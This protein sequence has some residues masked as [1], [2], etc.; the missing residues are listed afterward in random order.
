ML[1]LLLFSFA[2]PALGQYDT[3]RLQSYNVLNYPGSTSAGRNPHF[4]TIVNNIDPD[5]LVVQEMNDG[6]GMAQFFNQV[7][8]FTT[9]GLYDTVPFHNGAFPNDSNN[10]LFFK[11]SKVSFVSANYI[12]T[13]LRDIAEYVL[14]PV[15]S[16]EPIRIYSVHLKASSGDSDKIKRF[17]ETSILRNHLNALPAGTNFIVTGDFNIYGTDE[18]AYVKLTGSEADNDGR[19]FDPLTMPGTWNQSIYAPYHTQSPRVRQ[20][21]GGS[22]GGLDDRFDLFLRSSSMQDNLLTATYTPYGNDGQHFNDSVNQMPNT[23]VD[24]ITANAIHYASDHLPMFVDLIFPTPPS[25]PIL[26]SPGDGSTDITTSPILAWHFTPTTLTYHLEVSMDSLFGTVFI[27]DSTLTDT[28]RAIGPLDIA[29]TYFWRVKAKNTGGTSA[30]STSAEFTTEGM[31]YSYSIQNGWNLISVPF[32]VGS[33]VK[34][35]LFP[36]ATSQAFLFN[37]IAGYAAQDTL[38]EG[39]GYWLKF[40]QDQTV[41]LGGLSVPTDTVSVASGWNLMGTISNPVPVSSIA[42]EP[43]GILSSLFYSYSGSYQQA[44]TL[45]PGNAYWIKSTTAGS[46]IL[47]SP[48]PANRPTTKGLKP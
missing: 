45:L 36:T 16:A 27:N 14:Q 18:T 2:T 25:Q 1:Y 28:T 17:L 37:G 34:A 15:N 10:G 33:G 29:T 24:S 6:A 26:A 47:T 23:A 39:V 7:M 46:I 19:C 9:P 38:A 20:F 30:Y 32:D 35:L 31:V 22:N 42:T 40:D 3:L 13:A 44:D 21:E 41:D 12:T 11:P 43:P 4:R 8:N 5:I 48:S